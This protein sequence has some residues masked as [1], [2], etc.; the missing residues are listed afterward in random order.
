MKRRAAR[1]GKLGEEES[2]VLRKGP[3]SKREKKV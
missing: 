2:A 1:E 3:S